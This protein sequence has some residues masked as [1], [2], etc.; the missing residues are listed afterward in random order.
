MN[1]AEQIGIF[2]PEGGPSDNRDGKFVLSKPISKVIRMSLLPG[3]AYSLAEI[4]SAI[5][6]S[7]ARDRPDLGPGELIRAF[8]VVSNLFRLQSFPKWVSERW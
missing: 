4:S 7:L 1:W 8:A 2:V 3:D 6:G 5:L